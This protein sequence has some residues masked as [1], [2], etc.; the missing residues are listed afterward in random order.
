MSLSQPHYEFGRFRVDVADR[1]LLRDGDRVPLTRKAFATLC[2]LL[3]RAGETVTKRELMDEVWPDTIVGEATLSQNIYTVRRALEAGVGKNAIETRP[4]LGYCFTEPVREAA[5]PGPGRRSDVRS[6][7]VLPFRA[8]ESNPSHQHL[9]V[10]LADALIT[11]LS[12]LPDLLV[13]PS[14]AIFRYV[15]RDFDPVTVGKQLQVDAVLVGTLLATEERI[16]ANVQLVDVRANA[17]LWADRFDVPF[18]DILTAEEEITDQVLATIS[19]PRGAGAAVSIPGARVNEEAYRAYVRG[20]YFW[21]QRTPEG[22]DR[23]MES[24]RYALAIEPEYAKARAGL[25]DCYALYPILADVPP[26]EALPQAQ[27][28]AHRAME[29]DAG[30]AEPHVSLAYTRFLY[31]WDWAE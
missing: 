18:P 17:P 8:M 13:R 1:A 24:F 3:A 23:A 5:A 28:E 4:G 26:R 29:L 15:D 12:R 19:I 20:R 9:G 14:S 10:C 6:V 25:A 2:V 16:R 11:R 7:A 30:I 27:E 22:L 21:N 31:D